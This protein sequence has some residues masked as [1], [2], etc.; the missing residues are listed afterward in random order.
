MGCRITHDSSVQNVHDVHD[1]MA[2]TIHQSLPRKL[3]CVG[4]VPRGVILHERCEVRHDSTRL[5]AAE[6]VAILRV[7]HVP[8]AW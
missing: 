6:V 1:D 5:T 3:A 7:G 8:A 2:S 4:L